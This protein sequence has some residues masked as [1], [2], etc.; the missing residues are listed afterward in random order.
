MERV[1]A[2]LRDLIDRAWHKAAE[3]ILYTAE[4]VANAQLHTAQ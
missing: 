2:F 4:A 1:I 3:P